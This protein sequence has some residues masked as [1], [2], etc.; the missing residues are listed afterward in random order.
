MFHPGKPISAAALVDTIERAV[1]QG[2]L[3]TDE[4]LP[5]VRALAAATGLAPNTVA[6]AYRT[7]S[8]RGLAIGRGRAGT[9]IAVR[10]SAT[11]LRDSSPPAG[12]I[13]LSS[14]SPD[15]ALLPALDNALAS[16]EPTPVLYGA[17]PL[18]PALGHWAR[19]W[20]VPAGLDSARVAVV[21]GALDGVERVLNA[22]TRAGGRV[23]VEDPGYAAVFDLL[24][25]L[26]L[27]AVPVP[28]DQEGMRPDA[29]EQALARGP[30]EA[31]VVTPRAHNPTGAAWSA[32]RQG[33]LREVLDQHP[34]LLLIEDDHAGP[35]AGAPPRSLVSPDR[36]RWAVVSSV[37]KSLG[38]DLRLAFLAAD[39]HTLNRVETRQ[40]LGT[41]WVSHLLQRLVAALLA[42]P[43]TETCLAHAAEQYRQRR[44]HLTSRLAEASIPAS[45]ASGLNVWV[46]VTAEA[47]VLAALAQRGWWARPGQ[48]FRLAT[49]PAI[50][51]CVAALTPSQLDQLGEDLIEVLSRVEPGRRVG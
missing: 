34:K 48:R 35:V 21:G 1:A 47:P 10:P 40:Q 3:R 38:P 26:G 8:Q 11:V 20:A 42:D 15:P 17:D 16:I 14:G 4:R 18:D 12:L 19:R 39:P 5:P 44:Q 32:D 30:I 2:V 37:S 43:A 41:G 24:A 13:D 50:R 27:V 23:I 36:T 45:A 29:L 49:P 33:Q 6:A 9:F 22:H 25:A 46:P 28:L 7:L 51:L 31:V